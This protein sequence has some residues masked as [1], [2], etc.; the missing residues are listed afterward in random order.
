MYRKAH[1]WFMITVQ[2]GMK[3]QIE[4]CSCSC[5]EEMPTMRMATVTKKRKRC[6]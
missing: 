1:R 6:R 2:F 5:R 4:D 3:R